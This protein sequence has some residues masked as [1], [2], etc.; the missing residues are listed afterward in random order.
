[1]SNYLSQL[2]TFSQAIRKS[3]VHSSYSYS[4]LLWVCYFPKSREV[5][6]RYRIPSQKTHACRVLD[7]HTE[8][9]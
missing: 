4:Q 5:A 9:Q 1:M 3:I 8:W 7:S 2:Y 6:K